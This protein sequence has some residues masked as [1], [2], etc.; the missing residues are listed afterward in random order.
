MNAFS[1]VKSCVLVVNCDKKVFCEGQ[2]DKKMNFRENGLWLMS[3]WNF[4]PNEWGCIGFPYAKSQ[5]KLTQEAGAVVAIYITKSKGPTAMR[6]KVVGFVELSG[7]IGNMRDM[8]N[9]TSRRILRT[10]RAIPANRNRWPHVV[11]VMRAWEVEEDDR[12]I[13]DTVFSSTYTLA[14]ARNI[15]TNAKM[16]E[17]EEHFHRISNLRIEPVRVYPQVVLP[18]EHEEP[19]IRTAGALLRI[20]GVLDE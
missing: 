6:G 14:Q 3:E 17:M 7:G 16:V 11:V 10:H 9:F 1:V 13:V 2:K 20:R 5:N 4:T 19:A 8:R 12:E 18:P 15:G